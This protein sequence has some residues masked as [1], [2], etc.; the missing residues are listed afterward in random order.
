MSNYSQTPPGYRYAGANP[1]SP[2]PFAMGMSNMIQ[3]YAMVQQQ[4]KVNQYQQMVT[5]P[6]QMSLGMQHAV[7]TQPQFNY[8]VM[9]GQQETYNSWQRRSTIANTAGLTTGAA[10]IATTPIF[11]GGWKYGMS[12]GK[13]MAGAG[14]TGKVM[15]A[16]LGFG[17]PGIVTQGVYGL[18][19]RG[20]E[21]ARWRADIA[22]DIETYSE[23]FTGGAGYGKAA[24]ER[25]A[26]GIF[27]S[28]DRGGFFG[29]EDQLRIHKLGLSSGMI[30]GK[31]TSQYKKSFEDLKD[32]LKDV[33]TLM[34]TT[35]E[36]GLSVMD[37]LGKSGVKSPAAIRQQIMNAK[38]IGSLTG[39]GTQNMLALGAAGASAVQGTGW[40]AQ[41][42][43]NAYQTATGMV[44]A[45][46]A[47]NPSVAANVGQLGGVSQAGAQMAGSVMNVLKSGMGL[48]SMAAIMDP[49]TKK[50]NTSKMSDLIAGNMSAEAIVSGANIYGSSGGR[51]GAN[52]R[53]LAAR[54][55]QRNINNMSFAGQA[56]VAKGIYKAWAGARGLGVDEAS[57]HAFAGQFTGNADQATMMTS[58]LTSPLG[59]D[60]LWG[61]QQKQEYMLRSAQRPAQSN[62][63]MNN[64][65][66]T[67]SG[68]GKA[69]NS[70][71]DGL[72]N[73]GSGFIEMIGLSPS[74]TAGSGAQAMYGARIITPDEIADLSIY[75]KVAAPKPAMSN[76]MKNVTDSR[77][78]GLPTARD[79]SRKYGHT[80]TQGIYDALGESIS[81]GVG[82]SGS[83]NISNIGLSRTN[84]R[85]LD[86]GI[87]KDVVE[88]YYNQMGR[89]LRSENSRNRNAEKLI[90]KWAP[91]T[92]MG[93]T[94]TRNYHAGK[95][96][97]GKG[98]DVFNTFIG[99]IGDKTMASTVEMALT[100]TG[101][102]KTS[103]NSM[104]H[105]KESEY[106]DALKV[107][108][109]GVRGVDD[110]GRLLS[111]VSG[112]TKS[113]ADAYEARDGRNIDVGGGSLY[114]WGQRNRTAAGTI[115]AYRTN[116]VRA[117]INN[118]AA[119]V[120]GAFGMSDSTRDVL[121]RVMLT[122]KFDSGDK[123]L[124]KSNEVFWGEYGAAKGGDLRGNLLMAAST[125]E[126]DAISS[127]FRNAKALLASAIKEKDSSKKTEMIKDAGYKD[128]ETVKDLTGK[129]S[130]LGN[131]L[132]VSNSQQTGLGAQ[133]SAPKILNYWNNTWNI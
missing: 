54:D 101:S 2:S 35:I 106:S 27:N 74:P 5:P 51:G 114:D 4:E 87:N 100:G 37:E 28:M 91:G 92:D 39:M 121:S 60:Q 75:N 76:Y 1:S 118:K 15:G 113:E 38:G 128:I 17:V 6:A 84:K 62:S 103:L 25:L 72:Y 23:R 59:L 40:S 9:G 127:E 55:V 96:A 63:L 34:Q 8:G 3:D 53:L 123:K 64:A 47:N 20:V 98:D 14:I 97:L 129:V 88:A 50:I 31:D 61:A 81:A 65:R 94:Y 115:A 93:N 67:F 79:L 42:G 110:V 44:S 48:Q 125:T 131:I 104:G 18:A 116:D 46:T 82:V 80:R 111:K 90:S 32:N 52:N 95:A 99:G 108:G 83:Y 105:V 57:A 12:A 21:R 120:A 69:F 58:M 77:I 45:M 41:S 7:A 24:T 130:D 86:Q 73:I 132:N 107:A 109:K 119:L 68:I 70:V 11:M 124:L 112:M 13:A 16:A 133:Q 43:M 26:G 126:D 49:Y 85:M 33:V 22:T 102:Y 66:E 19:E 78:K 117:R 29:K 89:G 56:L 36:G 30:K 122:G 10:A 71:S